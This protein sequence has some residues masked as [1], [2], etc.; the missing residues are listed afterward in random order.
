MVLVRHG[1]SSWNTKGWI[2]GRCDESVLTVIGQ[3]QANS[4]QVALGSVQFD[5]GFVSPLQRAQQTA[6][7]I[8]NHR[9][10]PLTNLEQLYEIDMPAF[11]GLTAQE[12]TLR[13]PELAFSYRYDPANLVLDGRYP[14]REL[15]TQAQAAWT[16]I[17][18]SP[19]HCLLIVAHNAINQALLAT[20][21]GMGPAKYRSLVQS[22]GGIS[23]LN[24]ADNGQV[25]LESLNQTAHLG[26]GF[27][28]RKGATRI[29]LIRHGETDWNHAGR[30]QGQIDVPLNATGLDQAQKTAT[31][32]QAMPIDQLISSP[33]Q[34]PLETA[35]ALLRYHPQLPLILMDD[36]QEI[37]H[38]T[39]EG[40]FQ[41][42]VE[43]SYPGMLAMWEQHP[44][45]VQMPEGENL[46][47]IWERTGRVWH[48]ILRQASGKTSVVVAHDA[49]NKAVLC[50]LLGLNPAAFWYF[51]QGN[52]AVTIMDYP[53]G[54]DQPGVLTCMNYT[55]HLSNTVFDC[56]AAGAL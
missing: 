9:L 30:F 38:G 49:I 54:I 33:L 22:N 39:W 4:C 44:E 18:A 25:Q 17:L 37:S 1:Q 24:F 41:A 23:V 14:V 26:Q 12:V 6:H 51:K 8:W 10:E 53:E 27:P 56:T 46:Q 40:K 11:E 45:T 42:E 32:L 50:L 28:A 2:Q 19:G 52:G 13:F 29:L 47:Q 35:K 7:T 31:L 16:E 5:Q 36:L 20:A 15:W 21:L 43:A 34:R 48:E 55:A 3:Q